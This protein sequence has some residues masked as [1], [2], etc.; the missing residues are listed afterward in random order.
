MFDEDFDR[1]ALQG[2]E[3][4]AAE[5]QQTEAAFARLRAA[6]VEEL[7]ASP[8]AQGALRETLYLGVQVLDGVRRALHEAVSAGEVANYRALLREQGLALGEG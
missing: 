2:A 7:L 5:L 8:V 3:R 4:A 1:A 6:M